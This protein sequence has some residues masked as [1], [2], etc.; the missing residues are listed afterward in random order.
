VEDEPEDD[1]SV[2]HIEVTALPEASPEPDVD[3]GSVTLSAHVLRRCAAAQ[4]A[5]LGL[6]SPEM[7]VAHLLEEFPAGFAAPGVELR[8]H[9]PQGRFRDALTRQGPLRRRLRFTQDSYPLYEVFEGDPR[10]VPLSLEDPRMFHILG[11]APAAAGA[12]LLP[13]LD[14]SRLF[15]VYAIALADD[16]PP[17]GDEDCAVLSSFA[18]L[19]SVLLLRS[20]DTLG[21]ERVTRVD[22]VTEL[23]NPQALAE[24]ME[25]EIAR[26][27]RA[28]HPLSML[29]IAADDLDEV[30]RSQGD[31]VAHL[32]LRHVAEHLLAILRSTDVIARV[33]AAEFCVLLP[34]CTEPQAH[35]IATRLREALGAAPLDDGR[36]AVFDTK[37]SVGLACWDAQRHPVE[38]SQDLAA[39]LR[40]S[41]REGLARVVRGGGDGISV[42]HLGVLMI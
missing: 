21:V 17:L 24:Q 16:L 25:R 13:L 39:Q 29:Q 11:D 14:G 20:I 10:V 36:G 40:E 9:D 34:G 15:G 23:A 2:T 1:E 38:N 37:L 42:A 26:A 6:S 8:L 27:R 4:R 35:E 31:A 22:P 33:A 5:L 32:V 19:L 12:V 41:A 7:I 28:G 18:Q 30:T 3:Q